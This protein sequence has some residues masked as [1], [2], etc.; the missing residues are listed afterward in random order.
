DWPW[1]TVDPRICLRRH[2]LSGWARSYTALLDPAHLYGHRGRGRRGPRGA[3]GDRL[4]PPSLHG[5]STRPGS[6]PGCDRRDPVLPDWCLDR[7]LLTTL[8]CPPKTGGLATSVSAIMT[9]TIRLA[10]PKDAR[11]ILEIYAPFCQET[12]VSFEIAPP[13]VHELRQRITRTL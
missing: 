9:M 5:H 10:S 6:D 8:F 11:Q 2:D 13:T 1:T 4:D 12:A 3:S 7:D